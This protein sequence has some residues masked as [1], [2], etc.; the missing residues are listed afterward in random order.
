MS[1]RE[2]VIEI[3]ER[4]GF[5]Y[6]KLADASGLP[7]PTVHRYFN[8]KADLTGGRIDKLLGVLGLAVGRYRR[9]KDEMEPPKSLFIE[10]VT[11]IKPLLRYPGSKWRM[12]PD[13]IRLMPRH[14]HYVV[15]FGGSGAD[16]LR[17]PPSPLET[18]NDLDG[19]IYNLFQLLQDEK[20]L[21]R[22]KKKLAA[23]PAQSQ[24]H[25]EEALAALRDHADPIEKGWA[26]LV[27]SFQGFCTASPSKQRMSQWRYSRRPHSTAKSWLKLPDTIDIA[28]ER[29]R[30]VQLTNQ[31][32]QEI[33]T[34][35]D[36]RTTLFVADPP[37]HP[38]VLPCDYYGH[39]MTAE[40]HEELLAVLNRV[41]GFVILCGYENNLYSDVLSKWRKIK[42][43]RSTTMGVRAKRGTRREVIWLNFNEAGR[44]V[45]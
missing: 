20:Q 29:F 36:A 19:N 27:V 23:T 2:K 28:A 18:F 39:A 12:M 33:L 11:G 32:W 45:R 21:F 34:R 14:Q 44:R 24:R 40:E 38:D 13:L 41:K 10:P 37:Y 43:I 30:S 1:I 3:A 5:D 7:R 4:K 26:F 17:K 42:T 15:L 25:F 8:G 31:P 35:T 6:K 9:T 16:I 22:L